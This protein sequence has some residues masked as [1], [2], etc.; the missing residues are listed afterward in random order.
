MGGFKRKIYDR[1]LEW[2][3]ED[4][5]STAIL[6]EG[7]RR[8]GKTTIAKSFASN[9]YKS[10]VLLDF[11]IDNKAIFELFEQYSEDLDDFFMRLE[12][13]TKTKL[14]E[15]D[16]IIIF[17]EVQL[18]P[19]ARQMIKRLV[20]DHRYDYL[21]TGSL[22]SVKKNVQNILIPSEEEHIEMYPMDFEE[23][24]WALGD[25]VSADYI[26]R[27]Y[28]RL[29]PMGRELHERIMRLFRTYMIVGGMPAVV[30]RY[31]NEKSLKNIERVKKNILT[32]YKDDIM[33]LPETMSSSALRLFESVPTMLSSKKKILMPS[34]IKTGTRMRDYTR[35]S[36]WL[37]EAMI[38]NLCRCQTDPSATAGLDINDSRVK[39]YL[40]DTGL[41]IS[42]A[43]GNNNNLMEQTYD[44][45]LRGKL[46]INEGM[47]F[48]NVISQELVA[49]GHKLVFTEFKTKESESIYE[50]DFLLPGL[51]K[52]SP[53]EVKSSDS[54][55][56]KSLDVFCKKYHRR[57]ERPTIVHTKDLR[58]DGEV[59]YIPAYMAM[60]L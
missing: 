48:E 38:V 52:V 3:R 4:T 16:S 47:F 6:I 56:H 35:S 10:Y 46:S 25:E 5:G 51:D 20:A 30:D 18:Y 49:H 54:P 36:I 7:A 2:R 41:L 57:M 34:K 50:I 21:E 26:M 29:E 13:I 22:I 11:S 40:L 58:V 27:H 60:L 42:L 31:V 59:V 23:F 19:K 1:L 12:V 8:V 37:S 43:F 44:R 14:H 24:L 28:N 9:E 39:P 15:R 55:R 45:L 53:V 33:K 17:D 32:L